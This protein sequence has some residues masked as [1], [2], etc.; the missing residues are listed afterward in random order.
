MH[1]VTADTVTREM[2]AAGFELV[3]SDIVQRALLVVFSKPSR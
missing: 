1:G 2:K 3:S